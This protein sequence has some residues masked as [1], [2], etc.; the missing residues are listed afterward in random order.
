MLTQ[1]L[2][3]HV[4]S[5]LSGRLHSRTKQREIFVISTL[6]RPVPLEYNLYVNKELYK[7]VDARREFLNDGYEPGPRVRSYAPKLR[8]RRTPE[9]AVAEALARAATP[10]LC[11]QKTEIRSRSHQHSC[12]PDAAAAECHAVGR[13]ATLEPRQASSA[14]ASSRCVAWRSLG[15]RGRPGRPTPSRYG[16]ASK[17]SL[18][19]PP[20]GPNALGY[21]CRLSAQAVAS[22]G[23]GL[24]LFK[25]AV[26]EQRGGVGERGLVDR[27]REERDP[28]LC[29]PITQTSER[30]IGS[31]PRERGCA[32][33]LPI[34]PC[35]GRA[36]GAMAL[37]VASACTHGQWWPRR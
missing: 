4:L 29:G 18:S 19:L 26:R 22:S 28:S 16:P 20:T 11:W 10:R 37:Q 1:L 12:P 25:A 9:N 27:E 24:H 34:R 13:P 6:K 36:R 3:G 5:A 8:W 21:S 33:A 35:A 15:R 30:C 7:I 17:F 31:E 23:G 2:P 14:R 32:R